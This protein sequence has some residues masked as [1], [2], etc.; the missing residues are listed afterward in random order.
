MNNLR[1]SD[2]YYGKVA[3]K[4]CMPTPQLTSAYGYEQTSGRPKLTS[5]FPP[6]ADILRLRLD[7]RV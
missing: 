4:S 7:F 5:A 1:V 6:K 2:R 3:I